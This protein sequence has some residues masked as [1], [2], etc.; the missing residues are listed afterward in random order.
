VI[1]S[2]SW[3]VNSKETNTSAAYPSFNLAHKPIEIYVFLDPQ[4]PECWTI[5]PYLRKLSLEYGRFFTIRPVLSNRNGVLSLYQLHVSR[6]IREIYRLSAKN[7]H[8]NSCTDVESHNLIHTPDMIPLA[9]KAAELQGKRAGKLFLRKVQEKLF[10]KQ[11]DISHKTTLLKCA[12]EVGIDLEEFKK[13]LYSYAAKKALHSDI[14]LTYEM[15]IDHLPSIVYMNHKTDEQGIKISGIY[16]Y[17]I[18]VR[19]LAEVMNGHPIPSEKPPLIQFIRFYKIISSNEIAII[20]DW[21][22]EKAERELKKLQLKQLVKQISG[23]DE[24]FWGYIDQKSYQK[25]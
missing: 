14:K 7:F 13:D 1:W 2:Q 22:L 20:Y 23:K 19:V 16:P 10:L 8:L 17:D 5:E 15:D 12:N 24:S 21:P 3:L 11:Q 18:Y 9:I 25:T 4:C 6:K